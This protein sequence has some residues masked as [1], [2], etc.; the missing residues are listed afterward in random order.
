MNGS[1]ILHHKVFSLKRNDSEEE[2]T[3]L[4]TVPFLDPLPPLYFVWLVS[5][6]GV[7]DD[8]LC[9]VVVAAVESD[10]QWGWWR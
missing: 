2:Y 3:I 4:F 9:A 6:G 7:G 5:A 1:N 10:V 8:K